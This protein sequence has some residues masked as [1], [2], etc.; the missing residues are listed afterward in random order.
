MDVII[1]D[2]IDIEHWHIHELNCAHHAFKIT[3]P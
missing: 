2:G 1:A 3:A